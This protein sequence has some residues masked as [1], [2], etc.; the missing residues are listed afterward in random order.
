MTIIVLTSIWIIYKRNVYVGK[1][2]NDC[3]KNWIAIQKD[4]SQNAIS[5]SQKKYGIITEEKAKTVVALYAAILAMN[6]K[7]GSDPDTSIKN[8]GYI[9]YAYLGGQAKREIIN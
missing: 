8:A 3:I 6:E 2:R 5:E 1:V 7:V 4:L 9:V